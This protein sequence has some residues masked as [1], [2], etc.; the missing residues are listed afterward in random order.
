MA[1]YRVAS[2][3]EL[4]VGGLCKVEAGGADVLLVRLEDGVCAVSDAC[5]HARVS[6]SGGWLEGGTLCCPK[7]GGRFAVRSGKA[8][9]LPPVSPLET[10]GVRVDGDD[11]YVEVDD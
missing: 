9:K 2:L 6:L 7:H 3:A 8:V 11:V 10:Y 4:P 1:E 5:T